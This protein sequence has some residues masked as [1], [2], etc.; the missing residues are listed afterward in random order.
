MYY[1]NYTWALLPVKLLLKDVKKSF[2]R[3]DKRTNIVNH[4]PLQSGWYNIHTSATNG[5][6]GYNICTTK[7]VLVNCFSG[8][9]FYCLMFSL[10]LQHFLKLNRKMGIAE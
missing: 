7:A 6:G 5:S 2:I 3:T 4:I 10:G 1:E 9:V 8:L